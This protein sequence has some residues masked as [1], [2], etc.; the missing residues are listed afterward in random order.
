MNRCANVSAGIGNFR[1]NVH[2][3]HNLYARHGGSADILR[4]WNSH[5]CRS[6]HSYRFHRRR[7]LPVRNFGFSEFEHYF[8]SILPS[9]TAF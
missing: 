8:F 7:V 3:I 2:L 4:Y 9:K 6:R 1:T 5:G